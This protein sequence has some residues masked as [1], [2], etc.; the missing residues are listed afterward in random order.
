MF[1]KVYGNLLIRARA[2]GVS[3]RSL[4]RL[5]LLA[6]VKSI[7]S[8]RGYAVV[9]GHALGGHSICV[10]S[11]LGL[12][13]VKALCCISSLYSVAITGIALLRCC[14]LVIVLSSLSSY[15]ILVKGIH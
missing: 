7:V 5:C 3:L 13:Q 4:L 1:P 14:H 15:L 11:Q 12:R 6:T 10:W 2:K 8:F 9:R